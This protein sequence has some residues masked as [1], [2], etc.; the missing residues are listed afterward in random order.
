MSEKEA[1]Y[2]VVKTLIRGKQ[3]PK[4]ITYADG[5]FRIQHHGL[6]VGYVF[7]NLK[8]NKLIAVSHLEAPELVVKYGATNVMATQT[9]SKDQETGERVKSPY[10]RASAGNTALQDPSF[11]VNPDKYLAEHPEIEVTDELKKILSSQPKR[12]TGG[13]RSQPKHSKEDILKAIEAKRKRLG[14]D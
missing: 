10:I 13:R 6:P 8:T 11:V 1:L 2:E 14:L 4:R 7:K 9:Y 12:S 3:T 5:S